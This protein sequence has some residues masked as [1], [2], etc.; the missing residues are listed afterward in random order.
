MHQL[1]RAGRL[2]FAAL[3]LV[4]SCTSDISEPTLARGKPLPEDSLVVTPM[5]HEGFCGG[6]DD[7]PPVVDPPGV[8]LGTGITASKCYVSGSVSTDLD[9]DNLADICEANLALSFAPLLQYSSGDDIRGEPY[10]AA[11]KI[12]VGYEPRVE[13]LYLLNYYYDLGVV[14]TSYTACKLGSGA[15]LLAECDGHHGDSEWIRLDVKYDLEYKRWVLVRAVL[16]VHTSTYDYSAGNNPYVMQ[17]EYPANPGWYPRVWVAIS[18]HG[19]YP[20]VAACNGGG[21]AGIAPFDSCE[22][23]NSTMRVYAPATRNIGSW[24]Y[25]L[26][27]CV[28]TTDYFRALNNPAPECLWTAP[29]FYGWDIDHS[30]SSEG[31]RASLRDGGFRPGY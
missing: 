7:P 17:L 24:Q 15:E 10:W 14:S 20:S 18:K 1:T 8:Y 26:K 9:H 13:I 4:V 25:Q 29:L 22:S 16:S 23:N 27:N 31:N 5:C 12:M 28:A 11:Q 3:L 30:T 19:N 2:P 21:G 6:E